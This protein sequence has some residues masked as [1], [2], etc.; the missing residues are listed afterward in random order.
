MS[1]KGEC[2]LHLSLRSTNDQAG[3]DPFRYSS[4]KWLRKDKEHQEARHISFDFDALCR[5]V[6]EICPGADSIRTYEKKEG[7]SN[8]VFI[9]T[10]NNA[11][12]M[13]AKLPFANAGPCQL[14]TQSEVV[15]IKYCEQHYLLFWEILLST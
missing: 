6:V 1:M 11:K 10:T 7:G 5:R 15:T 3:P 4:G 12:L 9:F 13:V 2:L 14:V 8:R